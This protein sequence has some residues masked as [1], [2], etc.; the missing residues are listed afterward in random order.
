MDAITK[1]LLKGKYHVFPLGR[2][3][4]KALEAD[5][6]YAIPFFLGLDKVFT[7]VA[8]HIT[9]GSAGGIR[10]G[11][12]KDIGT[13][14]PGELV[15]DIGT[16]D[17]G[18]T[19]LKELTGLDIPITR[20]KL[21]WMAIL[22]SSAPVVAATDANL[23]TTGWLGL[24]IHTGNLNVDI[25]SYGGRDYS[26]GV[27]PTFYPGTVDGFFFNNSSIPKVAFRFDE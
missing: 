19:G 10:I 4:T 9:T 13:T 14:Y 3:G 21:Y 11:I 24:G 1:F 2:S 7:Q 22:G 8:M 15:S 18:S 23:V 27:L 5:K 16:I 26:Y 6:L 20:S 17:V 25:S 12:Y